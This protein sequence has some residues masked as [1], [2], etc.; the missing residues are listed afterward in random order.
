MLQF[1]HSRKFLWTRKFKMTQNKLKETNENSLCFILKRLD[2]IICHLLLPMYCYSIHWDRG[3]KF[4]RVLNMRSAHAI[5][6]TRHKILY[7]S[8]HDTFVRMHRRYTRIHGRRFSP[9]LN[10][11]RRKKRS[12]EKRNKNAETE[13][14]IFNP[15]LSTFPHLDNR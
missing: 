9:P 5:H 11:K 12:E 10:E 2:S 8:K 6:N 1:E 15:R 14:E 7:R 4:V 3:W 13:K